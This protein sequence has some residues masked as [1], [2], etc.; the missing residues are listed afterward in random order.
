MFEL[1]VEGSVG[2]WLIDFTPRDYLIPATEML[3]RF[4]CDWQKI[5]NQNLLRFYHTTRV[6][7]KASFVIKINKFC[8]HF[9]MVLIRIGCVF[10]VLILSFDRVLGDYQTIKFVNLKCVPST[11][12]FFPN[13]S[14]FARSHNRTFS[15]V[16]GY[17]MARFPLDDIW[18]NFFKKYF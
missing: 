3:A 8:G 16:N 2:F 7:V 13:H 15:A 14:C 10:L 6:S 5:A 18:V 4:W 11:E 9:T 1:S 17:L 12:F